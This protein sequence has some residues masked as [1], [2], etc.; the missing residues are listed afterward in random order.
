MAEKWGRFHGGKV[1]HIYQFSELAG[2]QIGPATTLNIPIS[3]NIRICLQ[4]NTFQPLSPPL[5]FQYKSLPLDVLICEC[6]A[7]IEIF[8]HFIYP[9][10]KG[11]FLSNSAGTD[12]EMFDQRAH[13]GESQVYRKCTSSALGPLKQSRGG[14]PMGPICED[15]EISI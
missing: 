4:R 14:A 12:L 15:I 3:I 2:F 8:V 6:T 9:L 13:H 5:Q 7:D 1:R 11:V 10:S